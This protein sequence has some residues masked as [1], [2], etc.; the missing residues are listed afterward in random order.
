MH[1]VLWNGTS[2]SAIDLHPVGFDSTQA[3]GISSAGQVGFGYGSLTNDHEHALFWNESS[4][5]VVD[6]HPY[7]I[8]LHE[9]VSS[10]AFDIADDGSIVGQATDQNGNFFAVLWTPVPEPSSCALVLCD[11]AVTSIL[12][13]RR[14][15]QFCI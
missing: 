7:L 9:F 15:R 11:I 6:L 4:E 10:Y 8:G 13:A 1:A 12:S 3:L 14:R 2:A 5:S